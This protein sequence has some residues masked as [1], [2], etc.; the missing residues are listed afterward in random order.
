MEEKDQYI[1]QLLAKF[2]KGTASQEEMQV[3]ENWFNSF[4]D[5]PNILNELDEKEKEQRKQESHKRITIL[6]EEHEH[7]MEA[8][9]FRMGGFKQWLLVAATLIFIFS[10]GYLFLF[11]NQNKSEVLQQQ[12]NLIQPGSQKATLTLSDGEQILLD[13]AKDGELSK[14]GNTSILKIK[15]GDL[16]YKANHNNQKVHINTLSTPRGGKYHITL[17]DGT[18]VWLN[19]ES[20]IE[21]PTDFPGNSREVSIQGEAY[22]EVAKNAS[23]PFL[24]HTSNQ[25][26]EVLGTHFNVNAYENN[27]AIKT[28]LLEGS[29]ALQS[30]QKRMLLI[31]GQ[32]AINQDET[33]TKMN[34]D[35]SEVIAWKEGFFDF[36]DANIKAVIEEFARWYAIDIE[37]KGNKINETFTGRIPR[38]WPFEKVW[39]IMQSFKSIQVEMQGRRIIIE[40]K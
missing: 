27:S 6:I 12:A 33:L 9:T 8:K 5:K 13:D 14:E 39:K 15:S 18:H 28:T 7:P 32:Q 40:K 38:D 10:A 25:V 19:A 20:S 30:H 2:E 4:S 1:N 22:F 11:S 24:V 29:I 35:P 17:A 26:V 34:V 16:V 21:F 36:T 23:K 31:P 3:L 37:Y